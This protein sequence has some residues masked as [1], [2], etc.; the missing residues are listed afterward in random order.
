MNVWERCDMESDL[1][2]TTR[3]CD[4][5]G[6]NGNH[7][8]NKQGVACDDCLG[9]PSFRQCAMRRTGHGTSLANE[10]KQRITNLFAKE[11]TMEKTTTFQ[12]TTGD[13]KTQQ[14]TRSLTDI[15]NRMRAVEAELL[16][17]ESTVA[18]KAAAAQRLNQEY[19][20][21]LQDEKT[22]ANEYEIVKKE[23]SELFDA[24]YKLRVQQ[25]VTK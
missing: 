13:T 20:K 7:W 5:C 21:A 24:R 19:Q 22:A 17:I 16:R 15:A 25:S 4:S 1:V 6:K 14:D 10:I 9:I 23:L 8:G 12:V 3:L 2:R 11:N 18:K